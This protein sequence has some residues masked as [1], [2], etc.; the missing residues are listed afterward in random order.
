MKLLTPFAPHI[1]EEIWET[2][3][4]NPDGKT[5]IAAAP[6]PVYDPAKTV[7]DQIEIAV[8]V[9]GKVRATITI[10]KD[11]TKEEALAAGRAAVESKLT[12]TVVKEIY[13]PGKIVNIVQK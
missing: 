1:A 7:D 3:G 5:F 4:M 13:V 8:Q 6:W 2:L 12:G 11:A 10:A 9:N